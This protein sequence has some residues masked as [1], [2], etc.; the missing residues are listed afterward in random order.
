M[1]L[2]RQGAEIAKLERYIG[3]LVDDRGGVGD[4]TL[5]HIVKE[6]ERSSRAKRALKEVWVNIRT[7]Y[8]M[9][10]PR[11]ASFPGAL[12]YIDYPIPL[13]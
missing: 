4:A 11:L 2:Q 13:L 5:E 7:L 3:Q 6:I 1:Q 9:Q 12:V 8:C 10:H